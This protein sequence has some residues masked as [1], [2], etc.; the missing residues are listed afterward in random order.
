MIFSIRGNKKR[1]SYLA[2]YLLVPLLLTM[3]GC[4]DNFRSIITD[5]VDP[6]TDFGTLY[7]QIQDAP[8]DNVV[9]FKI[10]IDAVELNPGSRGVLSGATEIDLITLQQ[11]TRLVRRIGLIQSGEFTSVSLT[12]ASPRIRICPGDPPDCS[13][14]EQIFPTLVN[15]TVTQDVS[16]S[17]GPGNPQ[18]LLIDFDIPASLVTDTSG[19]ITGVDPVVT[20]STRDVLTEVDEVNELGR[21]DAVFRTDPAA[22][23][24][25]FFLESFTSCEVYS[26]AVDENTLFLDY[27][28]L[29]FLANIFENFRV[30]QFVQVVG[31][32]ETFQDSSDN[33]AQRLLAKSIEVDQL[34]ET[35]D[36]LL[37]GPIFS[38]ERDATTNEVT[39]FDMYLQEVIPCSSPVLAN[40]VV[41]VRIIRTGSPPTDTAFRLDEEDF[42]T[43]PMFFDGP[44]DLEVGQ[45][46]AVDPSI[47]TSGIFFAEDITLTEQI[48][49]G[50]VNGAPTPPTFF[51][52]TPALNVFPDPSITVQTGVATIFQGVTGTADLTNQQAVVVRG[53][54]L[55]DAGQFRF[56]AQRVEALP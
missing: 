40:D 18:L 55:L 31:D 50:T 9:N 46:V 30:G 33:T 52:L 35:P 25:S 23:E 45:Q 39:G 42:M 41:T 10:E 2:F 12:F 14:T 7:I 17:I 49:R 54:L 36:R 51:E 29:G 16:L 48:I 44:E 37:K 47:V 28:D 21:V 43:D 19:T 24:G 56:L 32:I 26:F 1:K 20:L 11:S 3:T 38:L 27:D 8:L 53:L 22:T 34:T 4:G 13:I 15:D 6:S 5:P